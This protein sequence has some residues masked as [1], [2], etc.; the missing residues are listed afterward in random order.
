LQRLRIAGSTD[1]DI[2]DAQAMMR[3]YEV[4]HGT[5]RIINAL[6]EEAMIEAYC[7]GAS[8]VT[9]EMVAR[10][11]QALALV[12]L[13]QK[14]DPKAGSKEEERGETTGRALRG[15]VFAGGSCL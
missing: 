6:C 4:S 2:F 10:A 15:G 11:A 14:D 7:D 9:A 13:L 5:A 1:D 8:T 12:E 3:V